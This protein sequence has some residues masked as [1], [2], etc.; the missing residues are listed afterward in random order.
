VRRDGLVASVPGIHRDAALNP[1]YGRQG[2][3][4]AWFGGTRSPAG[5]GQSGHPAVG[6]IRGVFTIATRLSGIVEE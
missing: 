1:L 5:G 2:V 4:N 3:G 6:V